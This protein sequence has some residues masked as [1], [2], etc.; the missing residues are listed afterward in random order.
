M[1]SREEREGKIIEEREREKYGEDRSREG[2][3]GLKLGSRAV[4]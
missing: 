4:Y 3:E 1:K 2:S